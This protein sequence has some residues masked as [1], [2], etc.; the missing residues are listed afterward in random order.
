MHLRQEKIY[1]PS[2]KF[3]NKPD[4]KFPILILNI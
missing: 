1:K 3:Y 2:L 4:I